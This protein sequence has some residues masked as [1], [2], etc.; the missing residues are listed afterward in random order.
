MVGLAFNCIAYSPI[1]LTIMQLRE[2]L[3]I[4]RSGK[5][6]KSC[7]I[8]R[9]GSITK[10]C[11]S[12]LRKSTDA[13]ILEFSHFSVLEFLAGKLSEA[14]DLEEF[15]VSK[16]RAE[17]LMAIEYLK[18]I[19]LD[20]F[21]GLPSTPAEILKY[22]NER[23]RTFVLYPVAT[24]Y[25]PM[26]AR[27][28]Y[29][30]LRVIN[31]AKALFSSDK[32]STF[33]IWALNYGLQLDMM[34]KL[35]GERL[36][37]LVIH[38]TFTPL[39]LAAALELPDI[40]RHLLDQNLNPNLKSPAGN[41][42]QC[43]VQGLQTFCVNWIEEDDYDAGPAHII[44]NESNLTGVGDTIDCL[45]K[46][47]ATLRFKCCEPF[48]GYRPVSVALMTVESDRTFWLP[49]ALLMRGAELRQADI[50]IAT[51]VFRDSRTYISDNQDFLDSL[52]LSVEALGKLVDKSPVHHQ[53]YLLVWREAAH[54]KIDLICNSTATNDTLN[55]TD[56]AFSA[57]QIGNVQ[58]LQGILHQ[59]HIK[60]ADFKDQDGNSLLHRAMEP[61]TRNSSLKIIELLLDAGCDTGATNFAGDQPLHVWSRIEADD[62]V[63]GHRTVQLLTERGSDCSHQNSKGKTALH[64][65]VKYPRQLKIILEHQK[66]ESITRAME[67][68]DAK[69]Y[70]PFATSLR[71]LEPES[72][73]IMTEN[74]RI[75]SAMVKSPEWLLSLVA[76]A[77]SEQVFDFL[78]SSDLDIPLYDQDGKPPH[79]FLECNA[80]ESFVSRLQST[81]PTARDIHG[82]YGPPMQIYL[83]ACVEGFHEHGSACRANTAIINL[84][85]TKDILEFSMWATFGSKILPTIVSARL[86]YR[87][88][89]EATSVSTALLQLGYLDSYESATN[90]C[91]LLPLLE[92]ASWENI[93]H[94]FPLITTVLE[95][96]RC[97]AGF[98]KSPLAVR[99]LKAAI[100]KE[101][102]GLTKSLAEKGIDVD[103]R[104]DGW[105]ALEQFTREASPSIPKARA[106]FEILLKHTDKSRINEHRPDGLAVIHMH[107]PVPGHE[108]MVELLV[109][110]GANPNLR[111]K[112][113]GETPA[114]VHALMNSRFEH[115]S[116]LLASGADPCAA[117]NSGWTAMLAASLRGSHLCLEEVYNAGDMWERSDWERTC[118]LYNKG[119]VFG[120]MNGLH[121]AAFCGRDAVL[122]FYKE[123]GLWEINQSKCDSGRSP[124]HYA[125]MKGNLSTLE[126]LYGEGYDHNA[127]GKDGKTAL[128][129]AAEFGHHDIV[130]YL[131]QAGCELSLDAAGWSPLLY[132]H[133]SNN[134]E[135]VEFLQSKDPKYTDSVLQAKVIR[136]I[137]STTQ[138][139][140]TAKAF[141]DAMKKND[142]AWCKR[143][144]HSG[145][146]LDSSLHSCGSCSPLV[147]A[148][149]GK[150]FSIVKWLLDRYV[151]MTL[152]TCRKLQIRP[153]PL[154][155]L[156]ESSAMI[157]LL[158]QALHNYMLQGGTF[159]GESLGLIQSAI[160]KDDIKALR[161]LMEHL[162][163]NNDHYV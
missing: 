78:I 91:G 41:P 96:T 140:A 107:K 161:V 106:V 83:Q 26:C 29:E 79:P 33:T 89:E 74:I 105:S 157:D 126:F 64:L 57:V 30:D 146:D 104:V 117:C 45:Q 40:C 65:A 109:Q 110:Q 108:W 77:S 147:N 52:R 1:T 12:L 129:L 120:G 159:L 63:S 155:L 139:K 128:H 85:Y 92:C 73:V 11:S 66:A 10:Y 27:R 115:A 3:S 62:L 142:L 86:Y 55:V 36:V 133:Q 2:L 135:L 34:V 43:A 118:K 18:Y 75:N 141:E 8:I 59:P 22:V 19:Q 145:G 127:K 131:V 158:P 51:T 97:W 81:Y 143:L 119:S 99:L 93:Q 130:E 69:G 68:A 137:A 47:G 150:Q 111:I 50:E 87:P 123:H 112:S 163:A 23:N 82:D 116:A 46:A 113:P 84:L 48:W 16:S 72:A 132:A 94:V 25:W 24:R 21:K 162:R 148:I 28:H 154:H 4:P 20:N 54:Y 49:S 14:S 9:E 58:V 103:Q 121:L 15:H 32:T 136:G 37:Q 31:L 44:E 88:M 151:S 42:M 98:R 100:H 76:F 144:Y 102:P 56:Q 53:L 70:A 5:I 35:A 122:K 138:R 17:V 153:T 71:K 80:T 7:A 60:A 39:H 101:D 67:T 125:A 95:L 156:I 13:S 90:E 134:K 149:I 114:L 152:T 38:P 6:L 124:L 160:S 61:T